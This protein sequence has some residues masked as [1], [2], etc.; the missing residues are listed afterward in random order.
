[1]IR[2]VCLTGIVVLSLMTGLW[3]YDLGV[4]GGFLSQPSD[5]L[6]GFSGS[7]RL[8]VPGLKLE[9][10]MYKILETPGST[11]ST[12]V[13]FNPKL[14]KISLYGILGVGTGFEKLNFDFD[15][16]R[17]FTFLGF[18]IH[19]Y[20]MEILSIRGDMRFYNYSDLNRN[21][22]SAGIFLHL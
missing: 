3:G 20:L 7:T 21:R 22:L 13:K 6:V 12:G 16:Y 10:E 8:I 19:I 11:I 5:T 4:I 2:K 17:V 15:Q 9:F 14:G 18:G 1:M